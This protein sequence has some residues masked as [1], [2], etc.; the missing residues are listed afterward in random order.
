MLSYLLGLLRRLPAL[1]YVGIASVV[2]A[3]VVARWHL[4]HD[5]AAYLSTIAVGIG[6]VIT[7][8]QTKERETAVLLG[9]IGTVLTGLTTFGF[10]LDP[11][12]EAEII[13]GIGAALSYFLHS[14]LTPRVAP[15]TV[16][17]A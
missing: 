3:L 7:A 8:L 2:V 11:H 1:T 5:Q 12:L 4:T 17:R 15:E 14:S 10:R 13:A 9:F 16:K 6:A